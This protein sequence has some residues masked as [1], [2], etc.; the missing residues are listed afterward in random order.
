MDFTD[1]MKA[2]FMGSIRRSKEASF[3]MASLPVQIRN[4]A[5]D[6]AANALIDNK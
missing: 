6:A 1:S 3:T 4:A 2:D 5:L